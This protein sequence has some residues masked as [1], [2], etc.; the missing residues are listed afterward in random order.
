MTDETI[1]ECLAVLRTMKGDAWTKSH[2][3]VYSQALRPWGDQ[4]GKE[5]VTQALMTLNWRPSV[6]ELVKLS[7][8]IASPYPDDDAAYAEIAFKLSTI[9][10]YGKVHPE[11]PNV[12]I[13]GHPVMS[14]PVV[15]QIVAYCGGWEMLC[16]G[17]ANFQ[18]GVR[19]QV[20]SAHESIALKWEAA[21]AQL[22]RLT[23][24][25]R[26]ADRVHFQPYVPFTPPDWFVPGN[27][28]DIPAIEPQRREDHERM[29]IPPDLRKAM[30]AML[31]GIPD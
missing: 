22:L 7:A 28:L 26:R 18:E 24:K 13:L 20:R 11:N 25:D 6:A 16:S 4:H 15:S 5:T 23:D 29:P 27:T 9:G 2:D 8:R 31:K 19:K 30:G 17:E 1:T 10:L 3:M 14:H 12:R 21:V